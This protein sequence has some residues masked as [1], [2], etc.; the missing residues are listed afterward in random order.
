MKMQGQN[1]NQKDINNVYNNQIVKPIQKK[2]PN[3][4]LTMNMAG[5]SGVHHPGG[6]HSGLLAVSG[7]TL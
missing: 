4:K 1:L 6:Q 2:K 5:L 3:P 7:G